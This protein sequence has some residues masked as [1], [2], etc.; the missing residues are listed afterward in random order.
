MDD[1]MDVE[2][3]IEN[4]D[5][6][7]TKPYDASDQFLKDLKNYAK[8]IDKD[9]I[10]QARGNT[11]EMNTVPNG[12]FLKSGI[13]SSLNMFA[14]TEFLLRTLPLKNTRELPI[15]NTLTSIDNKDEIIYNCRTKVIEKNL[16]GT[17]PYDVNVHPTYKCIENILKKTNKI[18]QNN[19]LVNI[20]WFLH[21][22]DAK[23][24]IVPHVKEDKYSTDDIILEGK[25]EISKNLIFTDFFT[26][27]ENNIS[28][29][30]PQENKRYIENYKFIGVY[31][32]HKIKEILLGEQ[33][34]IIPC[35]QIFNDKW[36][37]PLKYS[38]IDASYTGTVYNGIF[39]LFE[40]DFLQFHTFKG[41]KHKTTSK[42]SSKISSME[43][44]LK[45]VDKS[46]EILSDNLKRKQEIISSLYTEDEIK[47]PIL[48]KARK[49][50]RQ[51][52][53]EIIAPETEKK[54]RLNYTRD[55]LRELM[56][57]DKKIFNEKFMLSNSNYLK[58]LTGKDI[59]GLYTKKNINIH[60]E[61]GEYF[62]IIYDINEDV[63]KIYNIYKTNYGVNPENFILRDN[64]MYDSGIGDIT[65]DGSIDSHSSFTRFI[66]SSYP[67]NYATNCE[68]VKSDGRIK[69]IA[70]RNIEKN[71]ELLMDYGY[72]T[73]LIVKDKINYFNKDIITDNHGIDNDDIFNIDKIK[74]IKEEKDNILF[75]IYVNYT[76][77][78]SELLRIN[79][80]TDK[81]NFFKKY[82]FGYNFLLDNRIALKEQYDFYK[83][84]YIGKKLY[85]EYKFNRNNIIITREEKF[86]IELDKKL[87]EIEK[88][89]I[90]YIVYE[91]IKKSKE[92]KM[93]EEDGS[94]RKSMKKYM[95]KSMKKS[96][97]KSKRK[98]MRKSKRKSIRKY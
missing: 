35:F 45:I 76:D 70:S 29:Q 9:L 12:G 32:N 87:K 63:E 42:T 30:P 68:F 21:Y 15:L 59:I 3:K 98:S 94:K 75:D 26:T 67:N 93:D 83:Q 22:S 55:G 96:M 62:G 47:E 74:I 89:K 2:M 49:T 65:I 46:D 92:Y 17:F 6:R 90:E 61:I 31:K 60:E 13:K 56:E 18:N 82:T 34:F 23:K 50:I 54:S 16:E 95:R 77:K 91:D 11:T 51:P 66:N 14:E 4:L 64:D 71:E 36:Y 38:S 40:T 27:R 24:L 43:I 41:Y 72:S 28:L 10:L 81:D 80:K 48:K 97:R 19:L 69:I 44:L 73:P 39:Q 79:C 25:E 1:E 33:L 84:Q 52:E 5:K 78:K 88:R 7:Q 20:L 58:K 57:K 53:K 85:N 37:V 86:N 8:L